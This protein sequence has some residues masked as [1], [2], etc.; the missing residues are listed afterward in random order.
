MLYILSQHLEG[1][2]ERSGRTGFRL[3]VLH[4]DRDASLHEAYESTLLSQV[5]ER[6]PQHTYSRSSLSD[7]VSFDDFLHLSEQVSENRSPSEEKVRDSMK[8][9]R[10]LSS[11]NSATS[12]TDIMQNL[13]QK[14]IVHFAKEYNCEAILWGDST[15][16]LAER[17]LAQTAKGRGFALPWIVADGLSPHG[18]PFYYPM[19]ELFS[20]EVASFASLVD[21]PLH[22]LVIGDEPKPAVSTKNTTI[23]DLM[24]Q[25]FESVEQD[26]PSI[27]ANVVKTAGKL[28]PAALSEIEKQCEL[29][30]MPLDGQAPER[31]RLCYGCIRTLPR[32]GG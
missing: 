1:Q 12:R 28:Q 18:I 21:P 32:A 5:K 14:L 13:K 4:V 3:H 23:D 26:Y 27:V 22:D 31:S 15:T 20:K 8:L 29:C 16:R 2:V 24:K 10:L 7:V 6:F 11:L 17:I 9:E 19:R 25:Y 30:D